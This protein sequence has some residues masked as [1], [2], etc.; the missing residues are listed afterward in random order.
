MISTAHMICMYIYIYVYTHLIP[1]S[2]SQS[3]ISKGVGRQGHRLF[4]KEFLCL[5]ATPCRRMPLPG[6]S[7]LLERPTRQK[8][9]VIIIIIIVVVV[10][11]EVVVVVVVVVVVR[12]T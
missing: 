11:V 2:R 6:H 3:D 8:A 10:V 5:D 7:R 9:V 12:S 1:R 4:C